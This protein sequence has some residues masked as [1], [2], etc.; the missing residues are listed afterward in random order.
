MTGNG[1]ALTVFAI[2]PYAWAEE[3]GTDE[4]KYA[5]YHVNNGGACKIVENSAEGVHHEAS[6]LAVHQPTAAP[7]PVTLNGIDD[8]ADGKRVDH[9]HG[10]L[11]ALCHGA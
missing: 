8:E 2:F 9:I 3:A 11:R 7:G 4:S 6:G 1:A 5:A 10:E